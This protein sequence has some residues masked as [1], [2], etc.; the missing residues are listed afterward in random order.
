MTHVA[1]AALPETERR[2]PGGRFHVFFRELSVALGGRKDVGEWGGGHPFDVA[3]CR[4]PPGATNWPYH[5]HAAQ[6]EFFLVT[7]GR[8]VMRTPAGEQELGP[9]DA[10]LCPPGEAHQL[11]N[12][13][14]DDLVYYVIADNPRADVVTYPDTG[15]RFIKPERK[16]FV[17]TER[18]YY[19]GEE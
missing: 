15:K 9:G 19:A 11:R 7:A 5:A 6:W 10:C 12:P 2:S 8:G 16:C 1:A 18:D 17:M 14:P 4:L 3:Q 13:G